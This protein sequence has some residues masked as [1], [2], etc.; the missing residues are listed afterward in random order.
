MYN[1]IIGWVGP[2]GSGKS[3]AAAQHFSRAPRAAV[4]QVKELR[5]E[6]SFAS[7]AT[8]LHT[9]ITGPQGLAISMCE[10]EFRL[11]YCAAQPTE[12]ERNRLVFDD[13][14]TFIECCYTRGDLLMQ[15]DEAHL[16]CDPRYIPVR[17]RRSVVMGRSR[18][19]DIDW[20]SQRFSQVHHDITANTHFFC[21]WSITEPGD[22]DSIASRCGDEVAAKVQALRPSHDGRR[23]GGVFEPGDKLWWPK[24]PEL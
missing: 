14:D 18:Y 12:T 8:N 3:Y 16:V 23:E 4:Y 21:F 15:I 17:F 13:F 22:L 10:Q 7:Q 5:E 6:I 24:E 20:I 11:V 19:V 9:E 2:T 1:R